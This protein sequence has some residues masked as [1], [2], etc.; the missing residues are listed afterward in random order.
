MLSSAYSV[1]ERMYVS[2]LA[3]F[4]SVKYDIF[5]TSREENVT[6][7]AKWFVLSSPTVARGVKRENRSVP[8][9][10]FGPDNRDRPHCNV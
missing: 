3:R 8:R 6:F 10:K 1:C 2:K 7:F 5:G 9:T 4:R